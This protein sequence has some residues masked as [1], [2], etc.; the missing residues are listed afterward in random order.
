MKRRFDGRAC[1]L[2]IMLGL[3]WACP[4]LAMDAV[5]SPPNCNQAGFVSAFENVDASGGGTITFSCGSSPVT[6]NFTSYLQVSGDDVIDGGNLVI[7]DGGSSSAFFQVFI[8]HS[9]S[10]QRLTLQHGA[11]NASHALENIGSLSLISVTVTDN[12]STDTPLLNSGSLT[13]ASSTF[14]NN[15]IN[16]SGTT[17]TGGAL[18]NEGGSVQISGTTFSAN[19]IATTSG[20]GGAIDNDSG[21]L[22]ITQGTFTDNSA[23]D[24]AAIEI[25]S[26][27]ANI[28]DS[29]FN[30]NSGGY[31]VALENDGG[32]IGIA[33]STFQNNQAT[34]GDGGA[35]W[36]LSGTTTIDS[37]QFL[38]NSSQSTGG[39]I[40]CYGGILTITN[41]A[42]GINQ[43]GTVG[44]GVYSACGLAITNATFNANVANG[45]GGGGIYQTGAAAGTVSYATITGNT[46]L[47]GAG[48]Y[49]D[50]S[51]GA[52]L[53]ISKSIIS[54]NPGGNC[55]GELTSA[56]YNLANDMGCGGAFMGADMSNATLTLGAFTNN[57]GATSTMLPQSVNQ[58][59][60]FIPP[61]QCGIDRDQRNASR[62]AGAG[63]DSGA[64]ELDGVFDGIFSNGFEF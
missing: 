39:A 26:G 46:S 63:C 18:R 61:A 13:I 22:H 20:S 36:N 41:S 64:V 47:F 7:F 29:T 38:G 60:D 53:T 15:G 5:I 43:A 23:L 45:D 25:A 62:P 19:T 9:L 49:N 30:A 50:P 51:G 6:F 2:A 48:L 11:F 56:G 35:I 3:L 32:D 21:D 4:A 40:S 31:G 8:N 52:S 59:I 57:G 54:A 12:V 33:T 10:L 1:Q 44:G 42:F 24:G 55:D 17:L 14:S 28:V 34:S 16:S 37:S 58:A 27:T